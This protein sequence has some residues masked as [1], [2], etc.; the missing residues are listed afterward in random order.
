MTALVCCL[1]LG[2]WCFNC[3]PV[4]HPLAPS[5]TDC[6][7]LPG[8]SHPSTHPFQMYTKLR[9]GVREFLT[10]A[11]RY[12]Q[13]WIHTNGALGGPGCGLSSSRRTGA[14]IAVPSAWASP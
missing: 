14:G 1:M 7:Q 13:L 2:F 12:F 11:S 9:P 4:H 8:L 3:T 10:H 5:P 6:A